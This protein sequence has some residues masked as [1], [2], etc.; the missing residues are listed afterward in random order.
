[1]ISYH[2]DMNS[3]HFDMKKL[4]CENWGDNIKRVLFRFFLCV[5][6]PSLSVLKLSGLNFPNSLISFAGSI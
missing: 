6:K 1:M 4:I 3:N 5:R 2:I